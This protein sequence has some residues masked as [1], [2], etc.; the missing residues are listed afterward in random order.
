MVAVYKTSDSVYKTSDLVELESRPEAVEESDVRTK[1][2]E[3]VDEYVTVDAIHDECLN[4]ALSYG[5]FY[6]LSTN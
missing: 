1:I 4:A 2:L 5:M 3:D 6:N